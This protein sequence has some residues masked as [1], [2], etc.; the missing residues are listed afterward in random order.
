M[1]EGTGRQTPLHD[2]LELIMKLHLKKY[3]TSILLLYL[4]KRS[5]SKFGRVCHFI[6]NAS[7]PRKTSDTKISIFLLSSVIIRSDK[8]SYLSF[9]LLGILS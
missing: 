6:S 8:R 2:K 3:L 4:Y 5:G 9:L 1:Q 7:S